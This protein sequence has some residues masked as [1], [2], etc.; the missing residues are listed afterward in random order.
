VLTKGCLGI[1]ARKT[2][3]GPGALGT[4]AVKGGRQKNKLI[5]KGGQ[6]IKLAEAG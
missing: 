4:K 6:K 5:P 1:K 2:Q 3:P